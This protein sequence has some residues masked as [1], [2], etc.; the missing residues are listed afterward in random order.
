MRKNGESHVLEGDGGAVEK[1]EV[2]SAIGV[3]HGGNLLGVELAVI[4]ALDAGLKLL[5]GEVGQI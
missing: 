3:D 2:V 4:S 1:L 5:L